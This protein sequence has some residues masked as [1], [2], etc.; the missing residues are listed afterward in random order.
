MPTKP[1]LSIAQVDSSGTRR[2]VTLA[3][4]TR[5]SEAPPLTPALGRTAPS[6]GDRALGLPESNVLLRDEPTAAMGAKK[7]ALIL[8]LIQ[9]LKESGEIAMIIILHNCAR[10][11]DVCDRINLV[12]EGAIAFDKPTSET[13]VQ[14]MTERVVNEYRS[15][16][17]GRRLERP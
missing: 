6:R 13:S 9:R 2:A 11:F 10:I 16:R 8:D 5:L 12:E 3:S 4:I 17:A 1:I 7:S 14:A 15:A